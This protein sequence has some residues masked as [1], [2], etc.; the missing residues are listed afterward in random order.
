MGEGRLSGLEGHQKYPRIKI[1]NW[2]GAVATFSSL[3]LLLCIA[4]CHR[5]IDTKPPLCHVGGTLY[6][7]HA[8]R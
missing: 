2:P 8:V 5:V 4:K 3:T 6:I 1:Y 7:N